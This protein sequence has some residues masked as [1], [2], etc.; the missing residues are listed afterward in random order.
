[1]LTERRITH[2]ET[3]ASRH[4]SS[5]HGGRPHLGNVQAPKT[6]RRAGTTWRPEAPLTMLPLMGGG[7]AEWLGRK[8]RTWIALPGVWHG[9]TSDLVSTHGLTAPARVFSAPGSPNPGKCP[10][11]SVWLRISRHRIPWRF[12]GFYSGSYH[13]W[14]TFG[15][16][17]ATVGTRL[18]EVRARNCPCG[19][20]DADVETTRG[21]LFDGT[22]AVSPR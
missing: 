20:A 8:Y 12:S 9:P 6:A 17:Q 3:G 21:K 22:P 13:A 15:F 4:A 5:R 16:I 18:E 10:Q 19:T 2:G 1:M 7:A 11:W 14:R